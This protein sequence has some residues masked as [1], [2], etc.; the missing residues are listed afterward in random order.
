[1][2]PQNYGGRTTL[3]LAI[4]ERN[5]EVSI[6]LLNRKDINLTLEDVREESALDYALKSD[7][8]KILGEIRKRLA[9]INLW[10][11]SMISTMQTCYR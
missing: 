1:M 8:S 6:A 11:V 9:N 2:N 10:L 4:E 7:N 3:M 5:D